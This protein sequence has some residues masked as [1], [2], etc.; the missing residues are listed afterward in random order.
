MSK[1]T[2]NSHERNVKRASSGY[3]SCLNVPKFKRGKQLSDTLF[4]IKYNIFTV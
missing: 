4:A 3:I 2:I 1:I